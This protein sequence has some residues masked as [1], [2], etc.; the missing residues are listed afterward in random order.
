MY[1][2]LSKACLTLGVLIF[3]FSCGNE[4]AN[5]APPKP[6]VNVVNAGTANITLYTEAVGQT[7]GESDVEIQPRV[8][9]WITGIFFK[10]GSRVEKGTLLYTIDD[11][12]TKTK[13][14]AAEADQG[15]AVTMM[16][17]KKADL[18]RIKP[19]AEMKALSQ[20]DLDA[21]TAAYESSL[22]EVKIAKAQVQNAR[23]EVGYTRITSPVS[24]VIGISKVQVGDYVN[25]LGTPINV[26]SA[27]G[28]VRVRFPISE[29][30]YLG[31]VKR[32]QKSNPNK[33]QLSDIPIE[34]ILGDGSIYEEKGKLA[35]TNRQ[36]DPT[37]GSILVQAVFKNERGILRPGQY[38]KVRFPSEVR[39]QAVVVPQQAV[40][41]I[42]NIYQVFRLTDSNRVKPVIVKV[43][44]RTGSNWVITQG[45]SAGDPL[46]IVG[47]A[48][49]TPSMEVIPKKMS[50]NY[51]STSHN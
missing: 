50:W 32:F 37:T 13:L 40:N 12:P 11:L 29:T 20:R 42:Q 41:Q 51:D 38:I 7:Y 47:N 1:T 49:I 34:L 15:R 3:L 43:G 9:G 8:E 24:G 45:V 44:P 22:D 2:T 46:V 25:R 26:V 18:D 48:A 4:A 31:F 39:N 28:E 33:Y 19:L 36:I 16:E 17:N 14:D 21:A 30:D 23:I 35:L 5:V 27:L 10:E 6:E